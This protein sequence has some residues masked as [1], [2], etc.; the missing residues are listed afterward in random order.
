[1]GRTTQS[2]RVASSL[3]ESRRVKSGKVKSRQAG[4]VV[5]SS[6]KFSRVLA[7]KEDYEKEAF[8]QH[9]ESESH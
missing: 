8:K 5:F 3:V 7:G 6:G 4:S 1:M 2:S 9:Y